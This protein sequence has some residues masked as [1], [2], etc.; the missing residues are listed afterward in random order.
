MQKF[1]KTL[2]VV[3]V[4]CLLMGM[5]L[6]INAAAVTYEGNGR[7]LSMTTTDPSSY[8]VKVTFDRPVNTDALVQAHMTYK[9]DPSL[10]DPGF[11]Q[12]SDFTYTYLT[13]GEGV[14]FTVVGDKV[15]S[16]Q[17][18]YQFT[19]QATPMP[20]GAGI[21][22]SEYNGV[23]GAVNN[24]G[25]INGQ[26]VDEQGRGI[27]ADYRDVGIFDIA[28]MTIGVESGADSLLAATL[29]APNTIRLAFRQ[30]V[31]LNTSDYSM[32]M[33]GNT[34]ASSV[35]A[36]GSVSDFWM[37]TVGDYTGDTITIDRRAFAL[38]IDHAN[39][40]IASG[41]V[42]FPLV[43]WEGLPAGDNLATEIV[44]GVKYSMMNADTG[45]EIAIGSEKDFTF[46]QDTAAN[47]WYIKTASGL[48]VDLTGITPT[49][50]S[51][52][53]SYRFIKCANERYQICADKCVIRDA[54]G[55][56]T[57]I[58][59]LYPVP[60]TDNT[61]STGWYLTREGE[62]KPLKILPFGDSIT[63][64]VN[65]D[66]IFPFHGWRDDLSVALD[67]RLD[68]Y[69]FV[70]SQ[71]SIGNVVT[72]LDDTVL[73]RHEGNPGWTI[74]DMNGANGIYDLVDGLQDKYGY[75]VVCLMIGI[76]DL[77]NLN[78]ADGIT[79]QELSDHCSRYVQLVQKI[80]EILPKNGN[81]MV[82]C[83]TL[84][85][86]K[87]NHIAY[88]TEVV[89]NAV[90]PA[91]VGEMAKTMPVA[92]NDNYGAFN[93]DLAGVS[94]DGIHLSHKGDSYV[95]RSYTDSIARYYN[96]NG[97]KKTHSVNFVSNDNAIQV[98]GLDGYTDS[99]VTG[100]DYTFTLNVREN[101]LSSLT[102]TVGGNEIT[103][104]NGVYTISN[105]TQD[106]SINLNA[107]LLDASNEN[108]PTGDMVYV[109]VL[110]MMLSAAAIVIVMK[111]R[112]SA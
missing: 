29:V 2:A 47:A 22:F 88:G 108:P 80:C 74:M 19:K 67:S 90:L 97:T 58:P 61:I 18:V 32:I 54:D 39:T 12:I 101:Y 111:K 81:G 9:P 86:L 50:V 52:P 36:G 109:Y 60:L 91:L 34:P 17:I 95:A 41:N 51:T 62:Q 23:C 103:P 33:V 42:V 3:L 84:T 79:Q 78:G 1:K 104:V 70:G 27:V 64:G 5:P 73:T 49:A 21:R 110:M 57:Q 63:F 35:V 20:V 14:N 8:A 75:D 65:V 46:I 13:S 37:V 66:T 107:T 93:G 43:G 85:P 94:S 77:T 100:G 59:T 92:L 44:N 87:S 45:R 102:V 38:P 112:I 83:S 53:I 25:I 40:P 106:L 28:W 30:P 56:T 89:F 96:A 76:N 16:N 72:T 4:V 6:S 48:Y 24:D 105:V 68:R 11:W 55:G 26:I 98:V 82:F 31:A 71:L 15:Y 69:V 99:V 7:I 10:S